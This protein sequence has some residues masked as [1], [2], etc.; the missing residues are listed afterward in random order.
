[1]TI[2]PELL[3]AYKASRNHM[4]QAQY[5]AKMALA[6]ARGRLANGEK[7]YSES[8][9]WQ[10]GAGNVCIQ[11][12]KPGDSSQY[13]WIENTSAVG[14]RRV[15]FADEICRYIA[16]RG[17]YTDSDF[18][19]EVYRGAVYQL[20]GRKGKARYL[21]GY[22]DPN[23]KG[24]AFICLDWIEG[25]K[26]PDSYDTK[27]EGAKIEAARRADCI[28]QRAAERRNAVLL[29]MDRRTVTRAYTRLSGQYAGRDAAHGLHNQRA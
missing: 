4:Q 21:A 2:S 14:L 11:E 20:P 24:A 27:D 15:G 29:E 23:N 26:L 6:I 18:Q 28:A 3:R 22:D 16:H 10:R 5:K 9:P 13:A 8:W 7:F 1:M 19:D 17:W 25:E 12:R